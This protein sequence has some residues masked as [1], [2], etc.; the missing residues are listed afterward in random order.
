MGSAGFPPAERGREEGKSIWGGNK[1]T[2][3]LFLE[4]EERPVQ[5]L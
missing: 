2:P 1:E 4:E 3:G 5:A